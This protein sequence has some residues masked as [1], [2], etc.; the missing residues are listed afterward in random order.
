MQ[1][2]T[3]DGKQ[4]EVSSALLGFDF[5]ITP[6]SSNVKLIGVNRADKELL[7]SFKTGSQYIY[8][9]VDEETLQ[10]AL[11]APSIGKFVSSQIVRKFDSVKVTDKLFK[12][13]EEKKA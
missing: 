4:H 12:E 1:T 10:A 13:I 2:L 7:V 9:G 3:F 8:S 6:Q 11:D 5:K